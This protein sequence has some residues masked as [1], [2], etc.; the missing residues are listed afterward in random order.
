MQLIS[1]VYGTVKPPQIVGWNN[2]EE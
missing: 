2:L 1:S